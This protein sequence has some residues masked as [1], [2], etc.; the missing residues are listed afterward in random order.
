MPHGN[1]TGEVKKIKINFGL[2][3][4]SIFKKCLSF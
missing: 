4:N 2:K 3:K 1:K